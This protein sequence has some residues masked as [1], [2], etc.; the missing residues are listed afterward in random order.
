MTLSLRAFDS[1]FLSASTT[2]FGVRALLACLSSRVSLV[3]GLA[4]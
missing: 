3:G 4:Q 2:D 1:A